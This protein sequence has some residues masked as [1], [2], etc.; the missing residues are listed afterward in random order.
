MGTK[1]LNRI[2]KLEYAKKVV[3]T[4]AKLPF[5]RRKGQA[6]FDVAVVTLVGV[7]T[8]YYIFN[9]ALKEAIQ[10]TYGDGAKNSGGSEGVQNS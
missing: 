6:L 5:R 9:D 1:K 2:N 8:G 3:D 10:K 4:G 7:S